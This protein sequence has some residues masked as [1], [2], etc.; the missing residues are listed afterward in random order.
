MPEVPPTRRGDVVDVMH[1]E[2]ISDPYRWL[3]DTD[4]DETAAWVRAQNAVT[5][6][7][8]DGLPGREAIRR[9]LT[10]V[11]DVTR[12][13]APYHHGGK[14]FF[15]RHDPG[16][17]QPMLRV[18][19]AADDDGCV[20]LDPN[21]LSSD[22]TVALMVWAVAGDG[23]RLVYA[24]SSAG[25]DWLTWRVRDVASGRDLDDVVEWSKFC[26]ASWLPD[27]SGFFYDAL[28]APTKG[29]EYLAT[30]DGRRLQLHMIGT[31]Q[32]EDELI[33]VDSDPKWEPEGSTSDDGRWLVVTIDRGTDPRSIIRVLDLHN[34]ASGLRDLIPSP[35]FDSRVV[36]NDGSI[37]F[38]LTDAGAPRKR[39]VAIDLDQ[40]EPEHWREVIPEGGDA[41][42]DVVQAG[43]RLVAH[44][45]HDASSALQIWS[46]DGVSTGDVALPGHVTVTEISSGL[47]LP[48]LHV[49]VTSFTDPASVWACDV[50]SGETRQLHDSAL[51]IDAPSIVVTRVL[52]SSADGTEVPMFL[53]HRR[54][55]SPTGDI[56]TMLYGYGG[57]D[58]PITPTFNAGRLV[59]IERG[60]LLAVA[61][62]R[63]G[64]EF[65]KEWYDAGRLASKQNVFNDFAG[66]ARWLATSGWTRA[67]RIVI[68]GASNGGLLVG[69]VLTQHPELIGAAVPEVGVLDML[70]FPMFTIGWAWSGDLGDPEDPEEYTW[71][72][73]YSPLHAVKPGTAYPATL[74]MTGDHDDRVVPGHS[75]KFAATLQP[76]QRG[77]APILIRIETSGGH[78]A[79]TPVSKLIE[80]RADMLA[81]AES[82]LGVGE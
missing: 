45:L 68:N 60:G 73:A 52:A 21:T 9:R 79:G 32:A 33:Y 56:P 7:Y 80:A 42:I 51:P 28:D 76:A 31:A 10:E 35:A 29:Q 11:W 66:C 63:G 39:V 55:V 26:E 48:T 57:F 20:L 34:R 72:R 53:L 61:N 82:A 5:S 41:L 59:W 1:G 15:T 75:F 77:S 47:D 64:G 49:G 40:P 74:I 46:A 27:G 22:G 14:W 69:A 16:V 2:S 43:G 37:F 24:T 71:V 36:G 6:S 78:G 8:L 19:D 70:R 54:D 3:E 67:E 44:V 38:V 4:S 30:N 17:N 12:Y 58:I 62:L 50:T 23:S 13:G 81:F 18:G 25:S 65:G